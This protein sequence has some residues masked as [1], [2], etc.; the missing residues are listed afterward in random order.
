MAQFKIDK[1]VVVLNEN[2]QLK[3]ESHKVCTSSKTN[4]S[5]FTT[6]PKDAR[7]YVSSNRSDSKTMESIDPGDK[8]PATDT[9]NAINKTSLD[10]LIDFRDTS[11]EV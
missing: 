10:R 7:K 4:C 1:L 2:I 11:R 9:I 6:H 5:H 8:M 3:R